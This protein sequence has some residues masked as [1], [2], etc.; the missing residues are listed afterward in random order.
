[1]LK[2]YCD[3]GSRGNPGKSACAYFVFEDEK[4]LTFG[5][6]YLGIQTNNY[7]EYNGLLLGLTSVIK[8]FKPDSL[9][10]Y[11]DSELVVKQINGLYKVENEVLK[12]LKGK[13]EEKKFLIANLKIIHVLREQ[14]KF[15]DKLVNICLDASM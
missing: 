11:L 14:N 5:C 8:E 9:E 4:L 13:I 1:M 3:G 10:V 6:K 15:A 7:A 2:L 12:T